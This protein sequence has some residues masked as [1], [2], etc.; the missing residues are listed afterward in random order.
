MFFIDKNV[1]Q[2]LY[3]QLYGQIVQQ[4]L[5]GQLPAGEKLPA[6]R[7]LAKELSVGRNTVDKAYQQLKDEGYVTS[8]S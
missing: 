8:S 7:S 2:P 4:I 3:E 1:G 5:S 6:T